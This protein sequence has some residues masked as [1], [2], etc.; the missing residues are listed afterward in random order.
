MENRPDR[1]LAVIR[2]CPAVD[3]LIGLIAACGLS[4]REISRRSGVS[5][6]NLSRIMSGQCGPSLPTVERILA[7]CGRR[8]SDLG[9]VRIVIR[10]AIPHARLAAEFTYRD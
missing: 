9:E 2:T 4:N 1:K 7:A 3:R 6:S 8:W 10:P 5:E